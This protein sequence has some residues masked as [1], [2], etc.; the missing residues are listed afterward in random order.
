MA[1][2]AATTV[3]EHAALVRGFANTLDV[4]HGTDELADPAGLVAWLGEHGLSEPVDRADGTDLRLAVALRD[5]IRAAMAAHHDGGE[6]DAAPGLDDAAA[7]LPLRMSFAGA[8]P[9][10]VPACG[11]V[12]GGLARLLVAVQQC[13]ADGSWGRLKLC[14]AGDCRWAFYDTSKNC[15]RVWCAMGVCGNR[16]KTRAYRARRR[17]SGSA[18]SS[19]GRAAP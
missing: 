13:V 8:D 19:S 4:E 11:G 9:H 5:G 10:L 7:A 3:A 6:P 12:R 1:G 18:A 15:T 2:Q 14:P 17:T 16:T